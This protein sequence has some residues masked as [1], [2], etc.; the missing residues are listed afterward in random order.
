MDPVH[1]SLSESH[2]QQHCIKETVCVFD[3]RN[4]SLESVMATRVQLH[5]LA[6]RL[7]CGQGGHHLRVQSREGPHVVLHLRVVFDCLKQHALEARMLRHVGVRQKMV[8][9]VK[10]QPQV[11]GRH[12]HAQ[13]KKR[14]KKRVAVQSNFW[15][16]IV[17]SSHMVQNV[18]SSQPR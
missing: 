2:H 1:A 18:W 17:I 6:E 4:D 14:R 11:S 5:L 7:R 13:A 8:H 12:T 3:A 9:C 10:V 16:F 15:H